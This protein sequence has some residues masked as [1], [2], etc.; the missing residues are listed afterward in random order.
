M[1]K[2]FKLPV[3][4]YE[5]V[6]SQFIELYELTLRSFTNCRKGTSHYSEEI[7]YHAADSSSSFVCLLSPLEDP[8]W[9]QK[10]FGETF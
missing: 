7:S 9:V 6:L 5:C 2:C 10:V 4:G 8:S 1:L 3:I